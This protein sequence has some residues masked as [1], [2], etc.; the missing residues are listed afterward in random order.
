MVT[1]WVF[2]GLVAL[3]ALQR[4]YE[5]RLSARHE[6]FIRARGGR[7]HA[8]WQVG[9]MKI[10]HT[11]W[12]IA[13]LVE[14][15]A[16]HRS[17]VPSLSLLAL[18]ILIVGQSLRYAAIRALAWRWTVNV[19]TL[20]GRPLV[21]KGIYR[22]LRHPNYLGV[23]LEILAVPLLHSAYVTAIVFSLAN[24]LL[25]AVRIRAEERALADA[26]NARL[27][28]GIVDDVTVG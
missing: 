15:H 4:I 22:Y 13:M 26:V 20:P 25:L 11:C 27:L 1:R 14:V 5:L 18:V 2:T 17:F 8:A 21:R 23:I 16:L 9:A 3:L 19:M 10:L 12:F 24:L 28:S 7:E 6:A